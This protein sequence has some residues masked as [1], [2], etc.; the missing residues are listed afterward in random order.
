MN[1]FILVFTFGILLVMLA[2]GQEYTPE[3]SLRGPFKVLEVIDGDTIR[4]ETLGKVRL[5]GVDTPEKNEGDKLD[6]IAKETGQAKK[7]IQATGRKASQ[8][9]KDL[10]LGEGV[11]L[12]LD[13][14]EFDPYQRLLAY[15]YLPKE[16]GN[17]SY[18]QNN[19]IQANLEILRSGW[20]ENLTIPPNVAYNN[21]F[22]EAVAEA[23]KNQVGMWA[24]L[25]QTVIIECI[26]YNPKGPD[27]GKELVRLTPLQNTDVTDW[28]IVD[29][30]GNTI[31]LEGL[32]E[33]GYSYDFYADEKESL[34][35]NSGDTA[36]LYNS[37]GQLV[38]EFSYE[39]G[40]IEACR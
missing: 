28:R 18:E 25:E 2:Y 33:E 20:A 19:Y 13:V 16:D 38:D 32:L 30:Q 23:R 22:L 29:R 5:L 6:R 4:I 11:W 34:W 1:K 8:F 27:E 21:L 36:K 14:R 9:T 39:G 35:G 15:V 10:L 7:D 17:W 12:E 3:N 40:N 37:A 31:F 24:K 26:V